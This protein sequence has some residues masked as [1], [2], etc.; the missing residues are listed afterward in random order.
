MALTLYY[1]SG[2]PYAWRVWLSLEHKGINYDLSRYRSTAAIST[3]L[4]SSLSI[5]G[6]A[7]L[8]S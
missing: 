8:C 7:F 3:S 5:R 2:S 1:L 4:N 6:A